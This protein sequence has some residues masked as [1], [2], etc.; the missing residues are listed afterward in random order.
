MTRLSIA[1]SKDL[2]FAKA[3]VKG[4]AGELCGAV[5]NG[6]ARN[7]VPIPCRDNVL[8]LISVEVG[9]DGAI[10]KVEA[11]GVGLVGTF[12]I[13][14]AL[15]VH[16]QSSDIARAALDL[17]TGVSN[18]KLLRLTTHHVYAQSSH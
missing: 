5:V 11:K 7:E 2:P 10:R 1:R 16:S 8:V 15:G 4:A 14:C 18:E 13:L 3:D 6:D 9:V 12:R 17:G